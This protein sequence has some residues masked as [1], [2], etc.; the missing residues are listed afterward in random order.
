MCTHY[1]NVTWFPYWTG[2]YWFNFILCRSIY[3]LTLILYTL[4]NGENDK[5]T[6]Y[7]VYILLELNR[8]G[9][10]TFVTVKHVQLV[11]FVIWTLLTNILPSLTTQ[12][13]YRYTFFW[14]NQW[15]FFALSCLNETQKK[16]MRCKP[17]P[18]I[19][20]CSLPLW[21]CLC[22]YVCERE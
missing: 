10:R 22:L 7:Y 20:I 9:S 11:Y 14:L 5:T 1:A 19:H 8:I 2:I 21:M 3:D 16:R 13:R 18:H 17:F 15:H 6:R 4:W 12:K